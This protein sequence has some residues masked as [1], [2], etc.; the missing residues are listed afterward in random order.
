MQADSVGL[1]ETRRVVL[2]TTDDPLVLDSGARLAPVEVAYETYGEL[3]SDASNAVLVCHALTGDAHAA[4]HHGDPGRVGWWDNLIGPG[5]PLDTERWHVVSANLLGGCKGTTGPSSLDPATGRPYGLRFP[6]FTVADLVKVHRRLLAS[7]G[8]E[9]L[10]AAIGGSLGAMQVLQWTIDHPDELAAG[11]QVCGSARL[12]AQNIAFSAVGRRSIMADEHFAGG[13]YYETGAR[14]DVGLAVAR[15]LAHLTYVSDVSLE[16]KFGRRLRDGAREPSFGIEFEVESYLDHQA[17][18]FLERFDANSYL[19]LSRVMDYFEPFAAAEAARA[20]LERASTRTLLVSFDTDWRFPT[21][22]S[23]EIAHMLESAGAPVQL[24]EI[25]S[26]HGHDSFLLAGPRLPRGRPD[27]PRR[28]LL[29]VCRTTGRARSRRCAGSGL[30]STSGFAR[31]TASRFAPGVCPAETAPKL[32]GRVTR[33]S[34]KTCVKA[35]ESGTPSHR[36][37][38]E[39]CNRLQNPQSRRDMSGGSRRLETVKAG[40]RLEGASR[41]RHSRRA[42]WGLVAGR[43][44]TT[45]RSRRPRRRAPRPGGARCRAFLILLVRG[46]TR[47]IRF[48]DNDQT[49]AAHPSSAAGS[50]TLTPLE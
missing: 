15:M 46:T 19:Y 1:V 39:P 8:I 49:R 37:R 35:H 22:H 31:Q 18:S 38:T 41:F 45:R 47:R 5:K 20:K 3:N 10:A 12:S 34:Q 25:A 2:C 32:P 26:P 7:L 30:K 33:E 11:I 27:V 14:P 50:A 28:S 9:R 6:I 13:D 23:L 44:A 16:E 48:L 4:G 17:S 29:W 24:R 43:R 21:R 42:G 36:R 40:T